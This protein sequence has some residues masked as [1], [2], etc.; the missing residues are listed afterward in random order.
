MAMQKEYIKEGMR[1][2]HPSGV[3][4]TTTLENLYALRK[5]NQESIAF[6]QEQIKMIDDDIA[7]VEALINP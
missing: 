5:F 6:L 4:C 2:K 1:I 3:V 7:K